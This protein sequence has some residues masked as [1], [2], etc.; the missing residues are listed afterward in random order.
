MRFLTG[1]L[2]LLL[3]TVAACQDEPM[4]PTNPVTDVN[5]EVFPYDPQPYALDIPPGFP[6]MEIP[7]DNPLTVDGVELGRFLF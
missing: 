1:L 7:V 2:V 4:E 5:L 3:L 6:P